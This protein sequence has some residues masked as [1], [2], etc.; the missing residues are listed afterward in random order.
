[1]RQF[2][3]GNGGF[4]MVSALGDWQNLFGTSGVKPL[5]D[6]GNTVT[7]SPASTDTDGFFFAAMRRKG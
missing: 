2:V 5:S 6:D 1:V 7:L 3:A 4:E